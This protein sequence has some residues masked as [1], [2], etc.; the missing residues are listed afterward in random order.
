MKVQLARIATLF[1]MGFIAFVQP[2]YS[3]TDLNAGVQEIGQ[4]I[5]KRLANKGMKKV[6]VAEFNQ[7]DGR[8]TALGQLF[9]EE[10]ITAL[11]SVGP[12]HL[13]AV[14]RRQLTK[15]LNEQR[16]SSGNLLDAEVLR[17][18]ARSL[19]IDSIV[20]GSISDLGDSVRVN[21]RVVSV[22]N[23]R[24]FGA[25]STNIP[26]NDMITRLLNKDVSLNNR[27]RFSENYRD[28]RFDRGSRSFR[29]D[30]RYYDRGREGYSDDRRYYGAR[31]DRFDERDRGYL[32][33]GY[34]DG[35]DRGPRG[36]A[37][38][39]E[40]YDRRQRGFQ[41]ND[42]LSSLNNS[43]TAR[44]ENPPPQPPESKEI[45][46]AGP[47]IQKTSENPEVAA[48]LDQIDAISISK[49]LARIDGHQQ[50]PSR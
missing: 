18:L 15:V 7:L 19:N 9:A 11:F 14:E 33:D 39:G 22:E 1:I 13:E 38:G 2:V 10:L 3:A 36:Y 4:Q 49:T 12:D 32:R 27:A 40:S 43:K 34:D 50:R 8:I 6:A 45:K 35:Y 44:V 16:I 48:A 5:S 41:R 37:R 17:K 42:S 25:A 30:D 29:R 20:T 31:E 46:P 47:R 24:I 21:V 23:A 28:E 26:K